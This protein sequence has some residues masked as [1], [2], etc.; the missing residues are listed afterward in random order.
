M[1]T[2][3]TYKKSGVMFGNVKYFSY[4]AQDNCKLS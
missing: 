2:P 4:I 3:L 1:K